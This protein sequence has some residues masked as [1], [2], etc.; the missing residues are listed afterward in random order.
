MRSDAP[1]R[2]CRHPL[3]PL[4][5]VLLLS[6]L[7]TCTVLFASLFVARFAAH[8]CPGDGCTTCQEIGVSLGVIGQVGTGDAPMG[9]ALTLAMVAVPSLV[10]PALLLPAMTPV[11]VKTRLDI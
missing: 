9:Q 8:D 1:R 7:L 2:W 4:A 5:F 6:V 10:L 11:F 3:R